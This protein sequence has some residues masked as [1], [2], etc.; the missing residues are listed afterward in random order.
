MEHGDADTPDFRQESFECQGPID[1]WAELDAGRLDIA[2]S[3]N[4]ADPQGE[5]TTDPQAITVK[6]RPD[7]SS[8]PP[9]HV[10]VSGWLSWLGEQT[11]TAPPGELS[12]EA[13]RRTIIDFSGTRLTV[14]SPREFPLRT[15]PLIIQVSAPSG[16]S[17]TARSGSAD[18]GVTGIAAELD[19]A[20]GSGAFRAQRC[21]GSA[22]VRTGSGDVQ[23]GTVLGRLRVRTGSGQ[24]D[25]ACL[26]GSRG[27]ESTGS[28]HTGSGDVRLG[29]VKHDLSARSSSGD[30]TVVDAWAGGLE[31]TTGSGQ[32]RVGIHRGVHAELDVS[33]GSGRAHSD[34]PVGGPPADGDVAL[35]VRAR[36]GS[37]DAL[38]TAAPSA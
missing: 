4:T 29:A 2:L 14:R 19:T 24:V 10:G 28:V 16:S 26:E 11:G 8:Q 7:L 12:T 13:L 6:I 25:V 18:V 21:A 17:I 15:V 20:T 9:W 30:L 32:L 27:T 34:L 33:S 23:L 5:N 37:G 3:E 22:A 1:I 38:V 35:R 31:L 36:T